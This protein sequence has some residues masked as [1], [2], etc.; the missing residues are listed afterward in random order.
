LRV[1]PRAAYQDRTICPCQGSTSG[2]CSGY[3]DLLV[4]GTDL[5]DYAVLTISAYGEVSI[6]YL[7]EKNE[8]LRQERFQQQH[9]P[10][11]DIVT[12]QWVPYEV[13][14]YDYDSTTGVVVGMLEPSGVRTCTNYD[15]HRQVIQRAVLP[16]PNSPVATDSV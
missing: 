7:T 3:G 8:L 14:E 10:G 11:I 2:A 9:N 13:T 4:G 6:S 1:M 5:P 12:A 15:A 16:A